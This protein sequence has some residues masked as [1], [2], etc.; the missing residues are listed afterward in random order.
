MTGR[1]LFLVLGVALA[2]ATTGT[3]KAPEWSLNATVIEACSCPM[4]CQCY[5]NTKPAAHHHEGKEQHFCRFNNVYR[6]N[7]GHYGDLKLDGAK[8]WLAGDLGHDFSTGKMDWAVVTFDKSV[9]PA[10]REAIGVILKHLFPVEW[11]SMTTAEGSIDTWVI[12]KD[13][14]RTTLDGGKTAEVKLVPFQGMRADKP[15]VIHNLKYWGAPRNEGFVM[16]PNEVQAYRAGDKPY[17]F[18][19][20]TGF[21][22]TIDMKS[23]DF[24]KKM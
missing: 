9:T 7:R 6:V 2:G 18:R 12:E 4:F 23:S 17:E 8:F 3:Q 24:E 1:A 5:F 20:T 14:A 22:V 10:Q 16:M 21:L 13:G 11:N 15:V 19:G